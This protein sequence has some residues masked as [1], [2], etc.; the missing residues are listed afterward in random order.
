MSDTDQAEPEVID[1]QNGVASEQ[2]TSEDVA[3][4]LDV[5]RETI[6]AFESEGLLHPTIVG[7]R[8]KRYFDQ[9][10]VEALAKARAN[11]DKGVTRGSGAAVLKMQQ[12]IMPVGTS[13]GTITKMQAQS[14]DQTALVAMSAHAATADRHL[15][16]VMD[17][18]LSAQKQYEIG[19][20]GIMEKIVH[21]AES[22]I[23]RL[24]A[25][26]KRADE[27]HTEHLKLLQWAEELTTLQQDRDLAAKKENAKIE[28]L[29]AMGKK[30][31]TYM[32]L[33]APGIM[34]KLGVKGPVPKLSADPNLGTSQDPASAPAD[35]KGAIAL[36]W[37]VSTQLT[38]GKFGA[39][40][41]ALGDQLCALL[42]QLLSAKDQADEITK[43]FVTG[44][45]AD[46][47]KFGELGKILNENEI[48]ILLEIAQPYLS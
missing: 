30:A 8:R 15:H 17:R 4:I 38:V 46:P 41:A 45:A 26:E 23:E 37:L 6:R 33:A 31:L 12:T 1:N 3:Q 34:A 35:A 2:L 36:Q 44:L 39:L 25:S 5:S 29:Q 7:N 20:A 24:T 22:S 42:D 18:W 32:D 43:K 19:Y 14:L 48:R 47:E 9:A 10:E 21:L 27:L 40:R 28:A 16:A 11:G 13:P